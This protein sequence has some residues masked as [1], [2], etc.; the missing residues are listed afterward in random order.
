MSTKSMYPNLFVFQCFSASQPSHSFNVCVSVFS[1]QFVFQ[2]F[3][4][5]WLVSQCFSPSQ[6]SEPSVSFLSP[7]GGGAL[8]PPRRITMAMQDQQRSIVAGKQLDFFP[9]TGDH[10]EMPSFKF[11]VSNIELRILI[12]KST[13]QTAADPS[14]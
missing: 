10:C 11:R 8:V 6:C 13:K 12:F 5:W 7:P 1:H 14:W 9:V 3:S 2:C 4:Q